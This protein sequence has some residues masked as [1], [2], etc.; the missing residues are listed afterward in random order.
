MCGL[1]GGNNPDWN[2]D[3]AVASLQQR[4]PDSQQICPMGVV[5]LGFARLAVMDVSP[6]ANQPMLSPNRDVGLVFNGE[7]YGFHELRSDLSAR[8][9]SFR[10]SSDTEVVL[11]AYLEWGTDFVDRID[12]MFAIAVYDRRCDQLLLFRNR[13]GIKPVYYY[14]A[15]RD[16]AF[17][18]ERQAIEKLCSSVSFVP[19]N[20]A[21]Y[22]F[23]KYGY[24]PTPKSLYRN[25][26]K[27]PP[28]TRLTFDIR[29][30]KIVALDRYWELPVEQ[31][32]KRDLDDC[33]DE[34]R[35]LMN[36]SVGE[37]LIADV[38]AGCFLSGGIDSSVVVA[39]AANQS[40]GLNTFS[41]GFDVESHSETPFARETAARFGTTHHEITFPPAN[42]EQQLAQLHQL[43]CEPFADT[44]AF[45]TALVSQF[46]SDRV[47]VALSGDGGDE[48]FGG[49]KW[50]H[51][52]AQLVRRDCPARHKHWIA[53]IVNNPLAVGGAKLQ[54]QSPPAAQTNS[55]C[56]FA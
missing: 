32:T 36:R 55:H 27:L 1:I 20:T 8:G 24:V 42:E 50:Y 45:P 14:H 9:H 54:E 44:S 4:G 7:I 31:N 52:Y 47:T 38:P 34:F 5:T 25:V 26:F 23:L 2:Y 13:A 41:V 15:G 12:G 17:A 30:R 56:M 10:T 49:Y 39:A 22:D 6:N 43:Y 19:D 16:F 35:T 53:Y 51:R 21:L 46:A 29:R 11:N 40:N 48:L 28:A 37:Q 18:S 33:A 3:A